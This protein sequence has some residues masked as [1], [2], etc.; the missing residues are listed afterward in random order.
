MKNKQAPIRRTQTSDPAK[1][2]DDFTSDGAHLLAPA[3][4]AFVASID[5]SLFGIE[6]PDHPLK[7][8]HFPSYSQIISCP[9]T[10]VTI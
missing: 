5:L 3:Q 1:M 6:A 2:P 10:I 4:E 7:F 9:G 8:R